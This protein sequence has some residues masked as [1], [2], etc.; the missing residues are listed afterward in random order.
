MKVIK[1]RF[2]EGEFPIEMK[3]TK[4]GYLNAMLFMGVF[5]V[6]NPEWEGKRIINY[7]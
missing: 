5:S 4:C 6:L 2:V 3:C 7:R 1:D